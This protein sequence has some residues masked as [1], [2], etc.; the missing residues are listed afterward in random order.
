[1]T[2]DVH[3]RDEAPADTA[4]IARVTVA[5]FRTLE[6]SQ[7]TEQF[8][9][10][11]LRA[12]DALTV[13]LVAEA[14]GRVIGHVAFSPIAISDGTA[15]WVGL[16]PLSVLPARQRKGIGTALVHEGLA[17]LKGRDARGCCVVGHPE[18]YRRFGF[19]NP[20][21]LVLEGVPPEVFLALPFGG[22]TPQ[23]TVS[24]H[25]AFTAAGPDDDAGRPDEASRDDAPAGG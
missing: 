3:I 19:E 16:G 1:M 21:G 24:F 12:A 14:A 11:A 5:A 8:I 15:D 2:N 20:L 18:Y 4:A 17:R 10:E 23:G 9:I 6:I 7:Y 13:S 25:A 22:P